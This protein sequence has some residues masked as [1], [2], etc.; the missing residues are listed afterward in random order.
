MY[1]RTFTSLVA[2]AWVVSGQVTSGNIGNGSTGFY[3]QRPVSFEDIKKF[4]ALSDTQI[5]Q[6]VTILDEQTSTSQGQY[7]K[8]EAKR[9]ELDVLLRSGSR[10]VAQIGQL[11]LDIYTLTNQPPATVQEG[12]NRAL[13]VL[14]PQQRAQLGALAEATKLAAAASQAVAFNLV[15]PPPPPAAPLS[16]MP[17]L[18]DPPKP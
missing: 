12:R 8:V 17:L 3:P 5:Q 18:P 4:L 13:A 11:T 7:E 14:T 16:P 10:D 9:A 6:L 15:D 2:G 1:R